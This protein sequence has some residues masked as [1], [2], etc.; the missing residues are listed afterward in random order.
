MGAE[1]LA[2][3]R[4][5]AVIWRWMKAELGSTGDTLPLKAGLN[6]ETSPRPKF[7]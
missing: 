4:L 5:G 6:R 7:P 3:E 2:I 1:D